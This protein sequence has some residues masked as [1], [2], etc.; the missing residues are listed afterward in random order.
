MVII[1]SLL[2]QLNKLVKSFDLDKE[3]R[4]N[5]KHWKHR[6]HWYSLE[7]LAAITGNHG[8]AFIGNTAITGN[9][10]NT[11]NTAITGNTT[12]TGNTVFTAITGNT[13]ITVNTGN[14]AITV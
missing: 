8:T 6:C 3:L 7:T 1:F 11:R 12:I 14:T 2:T 5:W 4:H 10:G 9:T 13:A